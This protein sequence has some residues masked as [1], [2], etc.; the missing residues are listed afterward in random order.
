MAASLTHSRMGSIAEVHYV[1]ARQNV[2]S[3]TLYSSTGPLQMSG[4]LRDLHITTT[5]VGCVRL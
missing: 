5:E 1:H 4:Q 3:G 2:P